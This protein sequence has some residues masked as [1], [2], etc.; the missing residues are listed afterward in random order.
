MKFILNTFI[1][2]LFASS[3]SAQTTITL[4]NHFEDWNLAPSWSDD[5]VGNIN[6][7]AITHDI[8]WVYFYIRTT[9]EVALDENTL[10]NSIRLVID[11]DN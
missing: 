1:F 8:D 11:F 3:F 2:C 10:P 7:A 4:D 6:K 5:G 9:N